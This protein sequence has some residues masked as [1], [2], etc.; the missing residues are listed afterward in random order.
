VS[1]CNRPLSA[2]TPTRLAPLRVC[3]LFVAAALTACGGGG[4]DPAPPPSSPSPPP[5]ATAVAV[6]VI[7]GAIRGAKVCIDVNGNG[8][9]DGDEPTAVT[10]AAGKATLQVPNAN[11][12]QHPVIAVV[13]TDA[14]DADLGAIT[15]PFTLSAPAD[16]P[17]VVSPLST[18]AQYLV[19][20][21]GLSSTQADAQVQTAANL[22]VSAYDDYTVRRAT[23]QAA[24]EAGLVATAVTLTLQEQF[25]AVESAVG[26]SDASGTV[27]ARAEVERVVR[28]VTLAALPDVANAIAQ[29]AVQAACTNGPGASGCVAQLQ[30]TAAN[31]VQA[32]GLTEAGVLALVSA[33]RTRDGAEAQVGVANASFRW[34]SYGGSTAADWYLRVALANAQED[35][36]VDRVRKFRNVRREQIGGQVRVWNFSRDFNRRNDS[37]WNGSAWVACPDASF[38]NTNSVRDANGRATY[39][40][41]DNRE[42]GVTV[43]STQSVAG[44]TLASVVRRI[45]SFPGQEGG[46]PYSRWGDPLSGPA[47]TNAQIEG[48]FGTDVFPANSQLQFVTVTSTETAFSYDVRSTNRV[49]LYDAAIT[50]GGDA[51][52]GG[53]PPCADSAINDPTNL[54][55]RLEDLFIYKGTPCQFAPRPANATYLGSGPVNDWWG[56]TTLSIGTIGNEPLGT[57]GLQL[58]APFATGN[59]LLRVAFTGTASDRKTTYYACLQR[60]DTGSTRN[61]TRIGDG[62]YEIQSLGDARVMTFKAVPMQASALSVDRVFVERGGAVYFGYRDKITTFPPQVRLNLEAANAVLQRLGFTPLVP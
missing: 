6:T 44:D 31:V 4:G 5:A 59:Q 22:S 11:V 57:A 23:E 29:P 45:R 16:K 46:L 7:D 34:L 53:T 52:S 14:V 32:S 2:S 38:Q 24:A 25:K 60:R 28:G 27:V 50:A 8:G 15:T 42:K 26:K 47:W 30:T 41:C 1:V 61:C 12:G 19:Q 54:A 55:S 10:D 20:T 43:R 39:N 40:S 48:F 62:T 49:F 56:N 13:G 21:Q 51:R 58:P 36:A 18:L 37:H 17:S 9:C 35:T 3:G 33:V